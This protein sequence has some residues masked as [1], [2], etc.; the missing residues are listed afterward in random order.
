MPTSA[1]E[2][3]T[4]L[5]SWLEGQ[6]VEEKRGDPPLGCMGEPSSSQL[7]AGG[8]GDQAPKRAVGDPVDDDIRQGAVPCRA[9][10]TTVRPR[11]GTMILEV[12]EAQPWGLWLVPSPARA[13]EPPGTESRARDGTLSGLH[14]PTPASHAGEA[15]PWGLHCRPSSA[16]LS[17]SRTLQE[18]R[19]AASMVARGP[20]ADTG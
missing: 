19:A 9:G 8:M 3:Q 14:D 16:A 4:T 5:A 15:A 17:P 10:V 11:G 2:P 18:A 12:L 13:P 6:L 7:P 20:R 1:G